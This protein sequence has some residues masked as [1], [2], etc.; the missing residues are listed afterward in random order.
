MSTQINQQL[1]ATGVAQVIVVLKSSAAA[2]GS[3]A[4]AS[5]KGRAATVG[6]VA[7]PPAARGLA[8]MEDYFQG[9]E[10]SQSS[11]L[12]E[13]GL[14]RPSL[15]M[16][17]ASTRRRAAATAVPP[18]SRFYPNLGVMF[19]TCN[20]E[21]LMAL[22][23][24]NRVATVSGAPQISLI[25]PKRIESAKLVSKVTWGVDFLKV[26]KLWKEGLTGK[27]IRVA[28]L[29]TGVDGKHPALKNAIGGFVEFD[30]FGEALTPSPSPHDT[31]DHGTH[32][33]ATIAGRP[34][35]GRSVGVAPEAELSSA[36]VIEGGEVVAR[37]LGGM[38]WAL[39]QGVHILSMSLG[40]R[41]WWEDFIPITQILRSQN[42]LPI[43]AVGNENAGTSRSPG[44]YPDVLSVG[45]HDK[46]RTVAP[47]SSSQRFKRA[48]EPIVPDLVAPGVDIISARPGGGY[49]SMDG[50][51]MATPH[52]AG[53][54]ALLLQA[55]PTA[56][57]DEVENA[58]FGSCTLPPGMFTSRANRGYP[59]AIRAL[60]LL[61]GLDLSARKSSKKSSKKSTKVGAKNASRKK[62]VKK[63]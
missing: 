41:G 47:F 40:F 8:G 27:G 51:S 46:N 19:G 4:A 5:S 31:D 29:D 43:I 28:H 15:A 62:P 57:I 9:S 44:N 54:A 45:A 37:V 35:N 63:R 39:S 52:V 10:L 30:F 55:K 14:T 16:A 42:V 6:A 12:A 7:P 58:I 11:A 1:K 53:V 50:T 61:T 2:S 59:D 60:A 17:S 3:V 21:G 23:A 38:D 20:R 49:Q 26:P 33:A 48:N 36:I 18:P 24:D 25:H 56:S 22:R 13:A 32:T 34:V